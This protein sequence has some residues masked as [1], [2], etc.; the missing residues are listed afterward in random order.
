MELS[1]KQLTQERYFETS[2]SNKRALSNMTIGAYTVENKFL[3]NSITLTLMK[4]TLFLLNKIDFFVP[5]FSFFT[6]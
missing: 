6:L 2:I 4:I 3:V 1:Q 5:N